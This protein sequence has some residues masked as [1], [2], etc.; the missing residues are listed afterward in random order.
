MKLNK[1]SKDVLN[2]M[3]YFKTY[4]R[5]TKAVYLKIRQ[6]EITIKI[7]LFYNIFIYKKFTKIN[8]KL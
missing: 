3:S 8:K 4:S 2:F 7:L 5:Q 1:Y 6:L